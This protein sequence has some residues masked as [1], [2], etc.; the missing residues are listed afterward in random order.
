[1]INI[2][3]TTLEII[4]QIEVNQHHIQLALFVFSCFSSDPVQLALFVLQLFQ[5]RPVWSRTALN[6]FYTGKLDKLK[7]LLPLVSFYYLNG[8]WR[9]Q[10]VRFGYDPRKHP[11][12]KMYQIVDYR[13][14]QSKKKG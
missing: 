1:M 8:P 5:Q 4:L 2:Y 9:C 11:E 10:W 14:R 6:S 7:Y 13:A 12:A 3:M